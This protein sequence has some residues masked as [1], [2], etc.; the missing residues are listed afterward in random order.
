MAPAE[1]I[2]EGGHRLQPQR[3]VGRGGDAARSQDEEEV[4]GGDEG[5]VAGG[6]GFGEKAPGVNFVT[7]ALAELRTDLRILLH[8]DLMCWAAC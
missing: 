4:V 1:P 6:V 8:F 2:V 3:L 5:A 7:V